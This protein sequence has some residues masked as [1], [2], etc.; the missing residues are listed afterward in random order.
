MRLLLVGILCLLCGCS[1]LFWEEARSRKSARLLRQKA[2]MEMRRNPPRLETLFNC[3]LAL[4][5]VGQDLETQ[6][7]IADC[8]L[9][10]CDI[11]LAE[12]R[13]EELEHSL[14]ELV[15][16]VSA[17]KPLR[18]SCSAR[19][20]DL[21][22]LTSKLRI[23]ENRTHIQNGT[24][25][26]ARRRVPVV[27]QTIRKLRNLYDFHSNLTQSIRKAFLA[28]YCQKV[29]PS[30]GKAII[31]AE[32]ACSNR[33]FGLCLSSCAFVHHL[34]QIDE[35]E[36]NSPALL[37]ASRTAVSLGNQAKD[38]LQREVLPQSVLFH[39][40]QSET[41]GIGRVFLRDLQTALTDALR[42]YGCAPFVFLP[43]EAQRSTAL[44]YI[45]TDG[46]LGTFQLLPDKMVPLASKT[47]Y[48]SG[49][50][51]SQAKTQEILAQPIHR[52]NRIRTV[53]CSL[54]MKLIGPDGERMV[55]PDATYTHSF[56]T[57]LSY[58]QEEMPAS[59]IQLAEPR[60]PSPPTQL[61]QERVWT[62]GEMLDE[63]RKETIRQTVEQLLIPIQSFPIFLYEKALR[64]METDVFAAAE[65]LGQSLLICKNSTPDMALKALLPKQINLRQHFHELLHL[66]NNIQETIFPL[67]LS[68]LP[69]P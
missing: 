37:K 65:L 46:R 19:L 54:R 48:R 40:L 27:M 31:L 12:K 24:P 8:I 45:I 22:L 9:G 33:Q 14:Q 42:R 59:A 69:Q 26:D 35:L 29:E 2:E 21:I 58:P 3:L 51:D 55:S 25:L 67:I 30:V 34:S 39:E 6:K 49:K 28:D 23:E 63:A 62:D 5:T 50:Y 53:H 38:A 68:I 52:Q 47:V 60:P 57:E 4:Q 13:L 36:L 61:L 10:Q 16:I 41:P 64:Q 20:T 15:E 1:S 32:Q 7:S 44:G 66:K 11:L 17:S 43:K 18:L 56:V